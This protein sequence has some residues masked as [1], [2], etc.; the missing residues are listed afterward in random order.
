MRPLRTRLVV[1]GILAQLSFATFAAEQTLPDFGAWHS[2]LHEHGHGFWWIF[3]LVMMFIFI[4]FLFAV[5]SGRGGLCRPGR[6]MREYPE[7][8]YD[9]GSKPESALDI[10]D[11][12]YARGEIEK[13]EYEEKKATIISSNT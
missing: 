5:R 2:S 13:E 8:K 12:R 9:R 11:K 10:L 7:G 3:P 6:W 4:F 1:L